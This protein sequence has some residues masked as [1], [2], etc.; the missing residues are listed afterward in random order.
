MKIQAFYQIPEDPH[1]WTEDYSHENGN[2]CVKCP[3]CGCF[4]RGHKRRP[5]CRQ[6]FLE[7]TIQPS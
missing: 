4:F 1:N 3:V 5:V 6:C 7:T 2:Y